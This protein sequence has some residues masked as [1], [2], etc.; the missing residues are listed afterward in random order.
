MVMIALSA[1]L[2]GMVLAEMVVEKASIVQNF[3]SRN[4]TKNIIPKL[5]LTGRAHFISAVRE[6]KQNCAD[7]THA[8]IVDLHDVLR[9]LLAL[10]SPWFFEKVGPRE[11]RTPRFC[12]TRTD[13]WHTQNGPEALESRHEPKRKGPTENSWAFILVVEY[14]STANTH[15]EGVRLVVLKTPP[16]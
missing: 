11:S 4:N 1:R 2:E 3:Q 15:P 10:G 5:R 13:L 12:G 6:R 7:S 16:E 9:V 14:S 8:Q